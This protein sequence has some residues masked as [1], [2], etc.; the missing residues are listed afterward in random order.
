[1][2]ANRRQ[3]LVSWLRNRLTEQATHSIYSVYKRWL[4]IWERQ[5]G[6]WS[7]DESLELL[8]VAFTGQRV[9]D[10]HDLVFTARDDVVKRLKACRDRGK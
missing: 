4:R 9:Y 10:G 3:E 5:A 7:K 6:G 1:M 8:I 2:V